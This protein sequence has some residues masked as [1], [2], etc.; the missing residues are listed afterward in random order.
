[1]SYQKVV[2]TKFG[3]PQVL[4]VI[5]MDDPPGPRSGEVRV[6]TLAT[7][8]CFT[9]TLIRRGKYYGIKQKPPF[10]PGYDV[11]GEVDALGEGVSDWR[12]GQRVAALTVTGAY[13]EYICISAADCVPLPDGVDPAEAV[14][15]VLTYITAFQM[16]HRL[17]KVKPH[18][19]ILVHG[20]SGAVGTALLQLGR[21]QSLEIY[22]TGS[23][24]YCDFIASLGAIPI[25]YQAE[26]FVQRIEKLRPAG[27]DAAFDGI[28]AHN[29]K[30]SFHCLR[31]GG[32]LVA[33]GTYLAA[34]GQGGSALGSYFDL[35]LRGFVARGK[36]ATIYSITAL[37]Q[38]HPD[39][40]RAD[41]IELFH[42][43]EQGKIKPV[44]S[45]KLLL[46]DA[47]AAHRLLEERGV[48]GKIVLVTG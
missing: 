5:A 3:G 48:K 10:A 33:Y 43:L 36:S 14:C 47:S 44:I 9:D 30:R 32:V 20:A 18:S 45:H 4:E 2:I 38:K 27:V 13:S 28:G 23:A 16:L 1:M 19:R 39:W 25:D 26:D 6:R 40:F 11:V 31:Q 41:L 24:K 7:S 12:L 34:I 35:M 21:L 8:A 42:L 46:T 37:K 22:G 29:F 17:A 15:L